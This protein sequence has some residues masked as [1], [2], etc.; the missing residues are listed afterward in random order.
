MEMLTKDRAL[1]GA[2]HEPLSARFCGW[3][4]NL[5]LLL[6]GTVMLSA[7]GGSSGSSQINNLT[8]SGNW[9]FT[10]A[11]PPDGS[12]LGGLQGGFLLQNSGSVTGAAVYSVSL[13]LLAFPCNSGSAP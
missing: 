7:C 10:M 3:F 12:F 11:N 1:S 2:H 6:A 13:P 4:V 9:Q 8:L 5:L